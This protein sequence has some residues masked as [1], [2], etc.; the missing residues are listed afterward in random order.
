M[1]EPPKDPVAPIAP[2]AEAQESLTID[3][4]SLEKLDDLAHCFA[5][6][7]R[8]RDV[9]LLRGDLGAGKTSFARSLLRALGVEGEV[10]SPTFTLIQTYD[11]A[12]FS[13]AHFDLY[14][15]KNAEEVEEIGFFDALAHDVCLIEWP[16][17]AA[18]F[19][20][21]DHFEFF[22]SLNAS[23]ARHVRCSV[24]GVHAPR[25]AQLQKNLAHPEAKTSC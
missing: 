6:L 1:R 11:V 13:I 10:P 2:I 4:P 23:G 21:R 24:Q 22:F 14:R 17:R 7:L 15:L 25:L 16:E 18:R 9:V 8:A 19:M 20:P 3:L 12:S 5:P